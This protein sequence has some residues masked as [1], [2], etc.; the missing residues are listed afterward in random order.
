[1][2]IL[3]IDQLLCLDEEIK[4]HCTL[5]S[6]GPLIFDTN[7]YFLSV[8]LKHTCRM[9]TDPQKLSNIGLCLLCYILFEMLRFKL[10]QLDVNQ[11]Q[12][13]PDHL[14]LWCYAIS[15]VYHDVRLKATLVWFYNGQMSL[16]LVLLTIPLV[17]L[18]TYATYNTKTTNTNHSLLDSSFIHSQVRRDGSKE[19]FTLS[20]LT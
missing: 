18:I 20:K 15:L 10:M 1:M 5:Y 9:R 3:Q 13:R 7:I 12:S 16:P 4:W 14:C 2:W 11:S 19:E 17:Q 8:A 6:F